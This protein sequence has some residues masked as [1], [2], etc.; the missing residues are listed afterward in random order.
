MVPR[1]ARGPPWRGL[2]LWVYHI[3]IPGLTLLSF[4]FIASVLADRGILLMYAVVNRLLEK[5]RNDN[6]AL[7]LEKY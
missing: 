5:Q 4:M 2:C 7:G 6:V 3:T 1:I